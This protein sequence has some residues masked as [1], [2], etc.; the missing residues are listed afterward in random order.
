MS[1]AAASARNLYVSTSG[2]DTNAGTS[3]TAPLRTI[4]RASNLAL[5]GDTVHVA[6][7]T[8]S[9]TITSS[10]N[11]TASARIRFVS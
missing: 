9:E 10:V 6:P 11:G 4:Q 5:P 2:R 8:Y 7:G 3:S 1:S